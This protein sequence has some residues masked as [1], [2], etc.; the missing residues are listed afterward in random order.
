MAGHSDDDFD[1]DILDIIPERFDADADSYHARAGSRLR[2]WLI[3]GAAVL[4]VGV[5]VAVGWRVVA[6]GGDSANGIPVISADQRP[7]K[8]RPDDRGG[9]QVPNQDKLV[10]G[11]LEQGDGDAKV[12]RLLPAAEQPVPPP[13][14]PVAP[15]KPVAPVAPEVLKPAIPAAPVQAPA[16]AVVRPV[17]PMPPAPVA[18][19]APAKVASAPL[20]APAP[21]P[22]P[23]KAAPVVAPAPPPPVPPA[24]V[25][26]PAALAGGDYLVQLGAL[27]SAPDAEKEWGRIQRSNA[28]VLGGLKS[29]VVQ[30][31]LGAKGV[32]WRL[33]AGPLSEQSARQVCGELKNRSQGCMV[34]RK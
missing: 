20:P 19:P 12:E 24:P 26:K 31:D 16:P 30:V 5:A 15:P 2:N 32:F 34:V 10:Y 9:M 13:A 14:A 25:V 27:R 7:I 6:G 22:A 21:A 23:V 28:D 1:R 3:L 8:I 29:D 33:R 4:A 18:A 11:R 17:E